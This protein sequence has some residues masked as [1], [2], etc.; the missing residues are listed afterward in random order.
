MER[1]RVNETDFRRSD[2]AEVPFCKEGEG[3]TCQD[4][5]ELTLIY[6]ALKGDSFGPSCES[7]SSIYFLVFE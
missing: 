1:T 7:V 3:G 5:D 6:I 4:L 2:A